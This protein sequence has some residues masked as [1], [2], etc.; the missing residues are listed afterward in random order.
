VDVL[1]NLKGVKV[2]TLPASCIDDDELIITQVYI[3]G[4]LLAGYYLQLLDDEK[5]KGKLGVYIIHRAGDNFIYSIEVP[6]RR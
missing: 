5:L 4:E 2:K 6:R 1:A 3:D